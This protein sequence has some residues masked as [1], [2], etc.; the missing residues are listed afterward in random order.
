MQSKRL[1]LIRPAIL[2][3][4]LISAVTGLLYPAIVTAVAQGSMAEQ[5]NGSL[6]VSHGKVQGSRLI[7]Q[8]FAGNGY[9]WSRPSATGPMPYNGANSSGSNL[10]PNNP[11]LLEAAQQRA[12]ALKAADPAAGKPPA[13]LLSASASGLDPEISPAAAQFQ[14]PRVARA[15]QMRPEQVEALVQQH[16]HLP[17]WGLFGEARVNVLALNLALD[18]AQKN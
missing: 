9:F 13:D 16:T 17:Q 4:G 14:V 12:A 3:L 11:A 10:G 5:A 2:S 15:R 1:S 7:G 18:A 6:L 8:P